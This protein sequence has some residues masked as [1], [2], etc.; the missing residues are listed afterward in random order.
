M[1]QL[2]PVLTLIVLGWTQGALA[3]TAPSPAAFAPSRGPVAGTLN[4][5]R[6]HQ[7][8]LISAAESAKQ[9]ALIELR[10]LGGNAALK[11]QRLQ[12]LRP[13]QFLERLAV[14]PL[15]GPSTIGVPKALPGT[16]NPS[17]NDPAGGGATTGHP[18]VALLLA[19]KQGESDFEA[20]CSGT[21]IRQNVVLTAAH[22][23]C[24]SED[25]DEF[26]ATGQVC[27]Q[28][29]ASRSASPLNSG[30]NW[31]VFFQHIG[32][33]DVK[34]VI[35]DQDYRFDGTTVRNDLALLVLSAPV[36]DINPPPLPAAA[37]PASSWAKGEI[38]G[39]GFS[40]M[41]GPGASLL[42]QLTQPGMKARG[43]VLASRCDSQSYLDPAGS[44]CSL[45]APGVGGSPSTVCGG[46]S[47]GPLR[48]VDATSATIG[49]TSG[50]SDENCAATNTVAFEMATSFH[51]HS[52][53]IAAH[54]SGVAVSSVQGL[55][56][57]FGENLKEI[58][59][60]R[61]AVPFDEQGAYLSEGWMVRPT[62]INV[63]ATMNSSGSIERFE[64]QDRKGKVLCSGK[65]GV[66][67]HT[68]NVDYCSAAIPANVQFRIVA[69]GQPNEFLQY[70]VA[71]HV[72]Q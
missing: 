41:K 25:P 4:T 45:F 49:V 57:A 68:P 1:K 70:V 5:R 69:K 3:Q 58:V 24:W 37:S 59:D 17:V 31:K 63:M 21:L 12:S 40:A 54:L 53:W 44:L 30:D 56:P 71:S 65:A 48:L 29:D 46:D 61:N 22:C 64:V 67:N 27:M 66:H 62:A 35:I 42:L 2:F 72:S 7:Q 16:P 34:Q 36:V 52:D 60:R 39:F 47:G 14:S 50:R 23:V 11:A 18:G 10:K 13:H 26:Y 38:I 28:G 20:K 15:I 8:E 43:D 32:V 19:R 55:W 33:R 51:P 6:A 9:S